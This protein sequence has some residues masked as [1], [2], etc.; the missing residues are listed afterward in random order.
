MSGGSLNYFFGLL[1]DHVGDFEDKEL[2]DLVHDLAGLFHAREW[3][4][5][6]DTNK[7]DWNE[8]RDAFKE[9]WF[10]EHGRQ[11]R[12]E[13]YLDEVRNEVLESFGISKRYCRTC[14]HW[15]PDEDEHF[16][17]GVCEYQKSCLMHRSETCE[18]YEAN[19]AE[20]TDK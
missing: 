2:D 7:G 15:T 9:K 16:N 14:Q 13:K 8:A 3:Y 6:A 11:E 17:Y 12:I 1:E 20:R 18:K 4:L 5:S 10:T 19:Q